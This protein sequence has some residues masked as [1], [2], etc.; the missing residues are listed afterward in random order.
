[1]V[2]LIMHKIDFAVYREREKGRMPVNS[3]HSLAV[4]KYNRATEYWK[5]DTLGL[6]RLLEKMRAMEAAD[7]KG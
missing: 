3:A 5:Q 6:I 4:R 1:M 7:A 2:F